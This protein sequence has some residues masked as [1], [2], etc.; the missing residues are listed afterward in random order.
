MQQ[1]Y[2]DFTKVSSDSGAKISENESLRLIERAEALNGSTAS[3]F[4]RTSRRG[5]K[6][7]MQLINEHK[8]DFSAEGQKVVQTYLKSGQ[9]PN[10]RRPQDIYGVRDRNTDLTTSQPNVIPNEVAPPGPRNVVPNEVA[11]PGPRNV[12]SNRTNL[13]HPSDLLPRALNRNGA[14]H[15][16]TVTNIPIPGVPSNTNGANDS[17]NSVTTPPPSGSNTVVGPID[18]S[19][20]DDTEPE[21]PYGKLILDW[22]AKKKTWECHWFPMRETRAGGDKTNNL[23]A[24]D[25]PLHKLDQVTGGNARE[26]EYIYSRKAVDS[27]PGFRWWG[28][29]NNASEVACTLPPPKHP[30]TRKGADGKSVT[31]SVG[32][33]QGLLVKVSSILIDRVDF[34]G[35]RFND[36]RYDDPNDPAPDVFIDALQT[37]AKDG[38]PFVLDIDNKEEVWNFPYDQVKIYE[39]KTPF[40]G[41]NVAGLP[42]DGSVKYYHLEMAGTGYDEKKRVYECYVQRD[43]GKVV[44]RGWIKTP[45]THNNPDF[46]WRPH[47]NGDLMNKANWL[48]KKPENPGVDAAAVYEIYMASLA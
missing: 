13:P 30:V 34:K 32:D 7:L 23:Y 27:G 9:M 5:D 11:S 40:E 29:C 12:N 48:R 18:V 36:P 1:M 43:G 24:L 45:H 25:G 19:P 42:T 47:P 46:A 8:A 28:H 22:Q 39:S 4:R 16:R 33:I 2:Q 31:F 20:V 41:G 15:G 14:I 35:Q 3:S 17:E 44:D 6:S 37:W 26:Y 38:L 21:G 10:A